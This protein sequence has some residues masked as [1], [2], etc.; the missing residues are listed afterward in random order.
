[1]KI[2]FRVWDINE[3]RWLD[4][5]AEEDPY[6]SLKDFGDGCDIYVYDRG[7]KG[8]V[9]HGNY[10]YILQQYTGFT[11]QSGKEI[12]EGDVLSFK[13]DNASPYSKL[14]QGIRLVKRHDYDNN[15]SLF[16]FHQDGSVSEYPASGYQL[17]S[18]TR[19][20][21]TVIGNTQEGYDE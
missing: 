9:S 7:H 13:G 19:T 4:P 15:L 8:G 11:D 16:G 3:S 14:K 17:N 1:M 12:Y 5:F 20:R 6:L 21:F 18:T 2:K 10:N